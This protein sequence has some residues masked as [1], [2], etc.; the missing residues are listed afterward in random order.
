MFMYGSRHQWLCEEIGF[1]KFLR[2]L[3]LCYETELI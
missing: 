3:S 2:N 1:M